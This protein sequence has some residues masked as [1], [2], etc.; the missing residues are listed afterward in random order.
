MCGRRRCIDYSK[1]NIIKMPRGR[2]LVKFGHTRNQYLSTISGLLNNNISKIN[3]L[4]SAIVHYYS[5]NLFS[6]C[7][8][9]G[10]RLRLRMVC[11]GDSI[12]IVY[13]HAIE[14]WTHNRPTN[15]LG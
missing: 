4:H 11:M 1:N 15:I 14:L 6:K 2:E 12:V 5:V 13:G 7:I 10:H 8:G 9:A 3:I